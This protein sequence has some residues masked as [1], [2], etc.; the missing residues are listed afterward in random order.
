[1]RNIHATLAAIILVLLL[2]V[3]VLQWGRVTAVYQWFPLSDQEEQRFPTMGT[4]LTEQ[5]GTPLKISLLENDSVDSKAAIENLRYALQYAKIPFQTIK[6]ED[7]SSLEPSPH[8]ILI[9]AGE[10]AR[11]WPYQVIESFVNRGGRLMVALRYGGVRQEWN[12]LVGIDNSNGFLLSPQKGLTFEKTLFPG[13]PN[14]SSDHTLFSHSLL[15]ITLKEEADLYLA[16]N[17]HPVMWTYDYGKGKVGYWN[18]TITKDKGTRG[19]LLQSLSLLPPAFVMHQAGIKIS[20]L[21][22]FPSP[23]KDGMVEDMEYGEFVKDVWWKSMQ[24]LQDAYELVYTGALIGT[25][26][27]RQRLGAEELIELREFPMVYYGRQILN[28]GG[29]LAMHGYN[30][31]PLVVKEDE[32]PVDEDHKYVP[33][34][35]KSIMKKKLEQ[36]EELFHHYFPEKEFQSYVPPSNILGPTGLDALVESLPS[37]NVVASLYYGVEGGESFIQEFEFDRKYP[38]LYHFPRTASGHG[39]TEE[40]FF[41]M[42]DAMANLGVFSHFIHPDD[43]TDADRAKGRDWDEMR[44]DLDAMYSFLST[45]FPYLEGLTQQQAREKLV[46]YQQSTIDVRYGEDAITISG[47]HMLDPSIA[48]VR[49]QAG[50]HLETGEF[51][52]GK[53]EGMGESSNLYIV[54]LR[55]PSVTLRIKEDGS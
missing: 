51:A 24:E 25:Y 34:K 14:L 48:L 27:K 32:I 40:D 10:H 2:C 42:T 43:R 12:D 18:T 36:T 4:D 33:W 52:F 26:E 7:L 5:P 22:D 21:D 1:M 50:K 17:D 38:E 44:E 39:D 47:E 41:L 30:H 19:L 49:L 3:A 46:T 9:V 8:H 45:H 16:V 15:D 54:T 11:G 35:R 23:I 31:Q 53:V 55:Q 37:V 28:A 29:E 6:E 13:Y 20:Y